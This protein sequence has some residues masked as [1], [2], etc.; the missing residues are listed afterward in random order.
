MTPL[1]PL[2]NIA[3]SAGRKFKRSFSIGG[4][5]GGSGGRRRRQEKN[6]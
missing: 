4:G 6:T 3:E 1:T 2:Q 5:G